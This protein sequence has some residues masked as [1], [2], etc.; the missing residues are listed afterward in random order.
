VIS[1]QL[2]LEAEGHAIEPAAR[3]A[4]AEAPPKREKRIARQ[5]TDR[6]QNH[7]QQNDIQQ[8][9]LVD[10]YSIQGQ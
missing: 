4:R 6:Q 9:S 10:R 7:A 5:S 1:T 8:S 2:S 3:T